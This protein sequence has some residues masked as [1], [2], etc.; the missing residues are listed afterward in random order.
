MKNILRKS[1]VLLLAFLLVTVFAACNNAVDGG[2]NGTSSASSVLGAADGTGT[3]EKVGVWEN[4]VYLSDTE[5]GDGE[6]TLK[7]EISAEGQ[8]ITLTVKTDAE[9]VGAALLQNNVVEGEESQYGLY[10]KKVNG[11]TA[12]YDE[13][14]AYWAFYVDGKYATSG[15]DTTEISEGVTYKLEYTK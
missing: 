12:D 9:T 6:K 14:K 4:A 5:L 10:V 8:S 13:N 2:G 15:I 11:I 1:F 3:V 7:V